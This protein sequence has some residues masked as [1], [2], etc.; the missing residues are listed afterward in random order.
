M[1]RTMEIWARRV[2]VERDEAAID[3]MLVTKADLH[4]L[5]L[6]PLVGAEGFKSFH[7]AMC[8]LLRDTDLVVDHHIESGSWLAVLCTFTGTSANGQRVAINGAIHARI[9]DGKIQEA[10]N[11][12]DFIGLFMQ[13][14]LLPGD[15]F[16]RCIA[17]QRIGLD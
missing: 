10:Y 15:T 1:L 16:E 13:L 12:F 6:Q 17:G 4:G 14:G 11:H 7:R 2:W 3:E 5:G 8:A 9:A